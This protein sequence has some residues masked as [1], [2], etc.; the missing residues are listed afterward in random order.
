MAEWRLYKMAH[1]Q[2]LAIYSNEPSTTPGR[3]II[4]GKSDL[5]KIA[6]MA[7]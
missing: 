3:I 7:E 5:F 1:L 6:H 2:Y 4:Q